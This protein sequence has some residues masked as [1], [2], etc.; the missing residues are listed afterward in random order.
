MI[1]LIL[2]DL[3]GNIRVWIGTFAVVVTAGFVGAFA[4]SL[5]ETGNRYGGQIAENLGSTSAVVIMFTAVSAIIVLSGS[6]NLAVTLQQRGYALWQLVGIR[7]RAVGL[8]VLAQLGIVSLF[9]ALTGALIALP[10]LQPMFVFMYE[11]WDGMGHVILG[12]GGLSTFLVVLGIAAIVLLGGLRGAR[13]ASRTAPVEALRDSEPTRGKIRWFRILLFAGVLTG[14]VFFVLELTDLS[15]WDLGGRAMFL[16]PLIVTTIAAAGP[17]LLPLVLRAWTAL[18]PQRVSATWF[19]AR[20]SARHRLSLS[21]AAISPLM[22]AIALSSG[23]YSTGTAL[24][25]ARALVDN[26]ASYNS[27]NMPIG[28]FMIFLGGPLL[29]STVGAAATVFMSGQAREREFALLQA[30]GSTRSAVL[31]A[32]LWEAVIYA[33]TAVLL[34]TLSTLA[35]A[36]IMAN[37]LGLPSPIVDLPTIGYVGGAGFVLILAATLAPTATALRAEIPRTLAVQ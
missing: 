30:A 34:G 27:F 2:A 29:L 7:P 33:V 16:S 6:A 23:L 8:I 5:I 25:A 36:L 11:G 13:S 17:L 14:T 37:A 22:V 21:T 9:G 35:T 32:A 24:N 26:E 19:L 10:L 1:R 4:A 31:L 28:A 12:L 18:V 20:N 15:L 3:I